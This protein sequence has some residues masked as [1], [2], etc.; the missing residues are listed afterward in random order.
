MRAPHFLQLARIDERRFIMACRHGMVHLTWGLVTLRFS[1]DKFRRLVA[2]LERASDAA[3]PSSA[4]DG[5]ASV[6]YR[7]DEDSELRVG[8]LALL[9]SPAEFQ[10]F[11]AATTEAVQRLDEILASG[12]WDRADED[13]APPNI[14]E[15]FHRFSFSRN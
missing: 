1:R 6:I 5:E 13:E 10:A 11:V 4:R 3:P 12:I 14:L 7:L 8:P 2:L 9:L 15:Q